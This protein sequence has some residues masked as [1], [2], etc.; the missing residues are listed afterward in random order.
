MKC[1]RKSISACKKRVYIVIAQ[2]SRSNGHVIVSS[3]NNSVLLWDF[4][5][6]DRLSKISYCLLIF[7]LYTI[8]MKISN[9]SDGMIFFLWPVSMWNWNWKAEGTNE[10]KAIKFGLHSTCTLIHLHMV[11]HDGGV[12]MCILL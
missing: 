8:F 11:L 10:L 1:I 6:F 3:L 7:C 12:Y 5:Y 9:L 4:R 2:E